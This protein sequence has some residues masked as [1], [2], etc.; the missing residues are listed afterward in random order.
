MGKNNKSKPGKEV[1]N[2]PKM[3]QFNRIIDERFY[4][5][6]NYG[7]YSDFYQDGFDLHLSPL[8][9]QCS[10]VKA[11]KIK[12][13]R[14]KRITLSVLLETIS[15][16]DDYKDFEQIYAPVRPACKVADPVKPPLTK[17]TKPEQPARPVYT[18]VQYR[19]IAKE[20]T[21]LKKT[22]TSPKTSSKFPHVDKS[23]VYTPAYESRTLP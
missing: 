11:S 7:R 17:S 12:K 23:S 22:D 19:I 21:V 18:P 6:G 9:W 10:L 8:F 20:T 4:R 3:T 1:K 16:D 13:R 14:L 5:A 2:R 15:D